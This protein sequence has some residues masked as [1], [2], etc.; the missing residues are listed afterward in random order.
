[1]VTGCSPPLASLALPIA[2]LAALAA[3]ATVCCSRV[4]EAE[5]E[6]PLLA[7][8]AP[9]MPWRHEGLPPLVVP[10]PLGDDSDAG[11]A[12][13]STSTASSVAAVRAERSANLSHIAGAGRKIMM[14]VRNRHLQILPDGTVNGTDHEGSDYGE[15]LEDIFLLIFIDV[16]KSFVFLLERFFKSFS[17]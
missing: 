12:V 1:M 5:A 14:Y 16:G 15:T 2:L 11:A 3:L 7:P 9:A 8:L 17:H 4:D 13:V 6:V 10:I